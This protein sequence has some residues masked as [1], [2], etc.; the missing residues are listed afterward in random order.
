MGLDPS[1]PMW[2]RFIMLILAPSVAPFTL[3]VRHDLDGRTLRVTVWYCLGLTVQEYLGCWL[4]IPKVDSSPGGHELQLFDDK[5]SSIYEHATCRFSIGFCIGSKRHFV[6][7]ALQVY[8]YNTLLHPHF[9]TLQLKHI[10]RAPPSTL[11]KH[12]VVHPYPS[13]TQPSTFSYFRE[14]WVL[15]FLFTS[16]AFV[17]IFS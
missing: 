4:K 10:V 11:S 6:F 17:I 16:L 15:L 12:S 5:L 8:I 1:G 13:T 14:R 3:W 2:W 7:R 9:Y